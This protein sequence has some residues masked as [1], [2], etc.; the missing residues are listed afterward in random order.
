M[1]LALIKNRYGAVLAL[2]FTYAF[3][4][5]P[6]DEA[7]AQSA[8][9]P[10][11]LNDR[12]NRLEEDIYQLKNNIGNSRARRLQP[13]RFDGDPSSAASL[14]L[15]IGD[16][17]EQMRALNGK[18]EETSFQIRQLTEK[19][20]RFSEDTELRFQD[21]KTSTRSGTKRPS[22]KLS[23]PNLE[24]KSL[25]TIP[26]NS[27]G[28]KTAK[29]TEAQ[30][31]TGSAR[32]DYNRAFDLIKQR[33]YGEAEVEFSAFLVRYPKNALDGNA[34][35]WLGETYFARKQFKKA[36]DAFLRGYTRYR[37]SAKAP[38]SLLKLGIT[39]ARLN[40]KDAACSAFNEMRVEFPR[41]PRNT[42]D[43]VKKEQRRVG[44]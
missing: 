8:V 5:L 40:Q 20:T 34:Q 30:A 42:R 1:R 9:D 36:A 28:L 44:C 6:H 4:G 17:E 21:L 16:M 15:R 13:G 23:N 18:I 19:F 43:R 25:G 37:T 26:S 12:L 29:L 35:Y 24:P 22:R 14:A 31:S 39:L 27:L 3:F 11:V 2:V 38:D 33:K 32:S 41:A 7:A 10:Y